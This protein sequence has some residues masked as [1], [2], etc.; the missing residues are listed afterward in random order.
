MQMLIDG[1][2]NIHLIENVYLVCP[3][4]EM[5]IGLASIATFC[6]FMIKK[7]VEYMDLLYK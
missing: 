4:S 2:D 1:Y 6:K 7:R 3:F 5:F